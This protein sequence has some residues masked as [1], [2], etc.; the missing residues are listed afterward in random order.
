MLTLSQIE[1]YVR[2]ETGELDSQR[3]DSEQIKRY[4]N[5]EQLR[6][7]NEL[8][9]INFKHFT[10]TAVNTGATFAEPSDLLQVPNS[11]INLLASTGTRASATIAYTTP[12][13]NLIH[14][15]KEAGT[16]GNSI[17]LACDA[18][19]YGSPSAGT[20]QC[21]LIGGTFYLDFA[22]G[23]LTGSQIV[24]LFN[25]DPIYSQYFTCSTGY[26]SAVIVPSEGTNATLSGGT[27]SDYYPAKEV[28]IQDFVRIES[29]AFKAPSS[30]SPAYRK[31][32]NTNGRLIEVLPSTVKYTQ[33]EYY[34][35]LPDLSSTT[36]TL[37]VP[38]ELEEL[39]LL[40]VMSRIYEKTGNEVK[41]K[42]TDG[43]F[44]I[45][46]KK[47]IENFTNK[48]QNEVTEKTRTESADIIN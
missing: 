12:T 38:A 43:Q 39:V 42:E 9:Q 6:V 18:G 14:T 15:Y 47:Y 22:S 17:S 40:G 48:R 37:K 3:V 25:A 4:V 28:S 19:T 10:K 23:A 41:K 27:G 11:I 5:F 16:G 7:Q 24:A 29:N 20:V 26:G 33:L 36:D 45:R 21:L 8:S 1:Q 46:W 35:R 31:I 34:Y 32:G 30:T 13:G 44:E 2:A